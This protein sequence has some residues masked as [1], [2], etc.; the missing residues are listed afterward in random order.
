[1]D[2][3]PDDTTGPLLDPILKPLWAAYELVKLA[4]NER[5]PLD[6]DLPERKILLKPDGTVDRVIVPQRLDAHRL[7]EEFMILANVAAAEMLEKKS[8]PLI[9]R[10]HDEPTAEKVH[11]LGEFLKTLDMP[12]SATGALRPAVFNRILVQVKG[13]DAE[14]LVNEVVLRSQAQAEYSA[15][16][17]GHF[18][19]N[20]R[21]YAH[22]TSPIRR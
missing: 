6:L 1:V 16:N 20:L 9:Y 11:N 14:S 18:G 10:V 8:L 17:Y 7:I 2:G 21:R 4:R 13:R 15:D 12:F 5:D 3:R 19:L 22:F